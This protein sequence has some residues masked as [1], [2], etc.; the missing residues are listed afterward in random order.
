[1]TLTYRQL[2][3]FVNAASVWLAQHPTG[4]DKFSYALKKL[5]KQG[6]DKFRK[7]EELTEDVDV[8]HCATDD[9]GVIVRDEQGNLRYTPEGLKAR[10]AERRA[11]ND[12]TVEF[13]PF[14]VAVTHQPELDEDYREA[15]AGI[16]VKADDGFAIVQHVQESDPEMVYDILTDTKIKASDRHFNPEMVDA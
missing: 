14:F 12:A 1:M 5:V 10:N 16:V 13:E 6:R 9:K 2:S 15:F 11:L 8:T 4:H 3:V 7:Y